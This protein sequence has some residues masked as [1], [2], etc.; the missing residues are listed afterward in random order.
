MG[1]GAAVCYDGGVAQVASGLKYIHSDRIVHRDLKPENI[2]ISVNPD[3][4]AKLPITELAAAVRNVVHIGDFG[5]SAK[6]LCPSQQTPVTA[7]PSLDLPRM[8]AAS[9]AEG[10]RGVTAHA[11]GRTYS[12]ASSTDFEVM[13]QKAR[14]HS[15]FTIPRN[16][17][18][19]TDVGMLTFG[20]GRSPYTDGKRNEMPSGGVWG[21][22]ASL[23]TDGGHGGVGSPMY[24]APEQTAGVVGSCGTAADIY[25]LGIVLM[26]CVIA[27]RSLHERER[28][29]D[30][31]KTLGTVPAEMEMKWPALAAWA[32]TLVAHNSALRPSASAVVDQLRQ[33]VDRP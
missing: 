31:F 5:L 11:H 23:A 2:F 20:S 27:P 8:R 16:T 24:A 13:Q 33:W 10:V 26:E 3:A 30:G 21:S 25:S 14:N 28:V 19:G 12:A 29:L 32:K 1:W 4:V 7:G 22:C 6:L 15:A 17:S 18:A 9:T